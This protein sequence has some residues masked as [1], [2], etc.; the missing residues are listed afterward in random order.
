MRKLTHDLGLQ[1]CNSKANPRFKLIAF[2]VGVIGIFIPAITHANNDVSGTVISVIDG[3]TLEVSNGEKE[4]HKLL[5]FGIDSPEL[6]QEYGDQAKEFLKKLVLNKNV[7]VQFKGKDRMGNYLA[8]VM[9]N[10]IVDPRVELLKE[11]LAWTEE[12]NPLTEL[13]PYRTIAQQKGLG[14][15]E[16][17]NPVPPWTYRRQQSMRQPKTS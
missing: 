5:L 2:V 8:V 7:T 11:G 12:K 17:K 10:G 9:I 16:Q 14:L 6:G 15:W 3:N 4:K 1:L 13:E